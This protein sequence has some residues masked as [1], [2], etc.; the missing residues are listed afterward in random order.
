MSPWGTCFYAGTLPSFG[1]VFYNLV[2]SLQK[3]LNMTILRG[4]HSLTSCPLDSDMHVTLEHLFRS[5]IILIWYLRSSSKKEDPTQSD[6][7]QQDSPYSSSAVRPAQKS[8]PFPDPHDL[9]NLKIPRM[10]CG[11]EPHPSSA[12]LMY[13]SPLQAVSDSPTQGNPGRVSSLWNVEACRKSRCRHSA[14]FLVV[15]ILSLFL[16]KTVA[17]PCVQFIWKRKNKLFFV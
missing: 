4:T 17:Y 2:Q 14:A 16:I 1:P 5:F 13:K 10:L 11:K 8:W 9:K 6:E 7:S 3:T 12:S 15:R